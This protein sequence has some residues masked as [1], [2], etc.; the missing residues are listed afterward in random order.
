MKAV[1][2]AYEYIL[3]GKTGFYNYETEFRK[4]DGSVL[5]IEWNATVLRDNSNY[6]SSVATIGQDV[7]SRKRA[8]T[9]LI[10]AKSKAEESDK[11][12]SIFL[13]NMSHEI[14]T[15]MNAIM[16]FSALLGNDGVSEAEKHQFINI[17][18]SSGDRLLNIINDI[19][20]ISKIEAKQLSIT[21]SEFNLSDIFRISLDSFRNSELLKAKSEINLTIRIDERLKHT[22][23]IS[24]RYRIQQVLDNL[25]SNSIKYTEK[26]EIETGFRIVDE[27][28]TDMIEAWVKDTGIGI[29]DELHEIIFERFRQADENKFH[30]GAGLGLSITKGIID[31]LNG[32]IWFASIIKQGTTFYF[33]IPLVISENKPLSEMKTASGVPDL[34]GKT[35]IIA[36]DDYNSFYY[37]RLLLKNLNANVLHAENGSVLMRLV[38]HK[39]P[40]L[41][42]LDINMPVMSGYQ[43]LDELKRL[44][45]KTKIIAQTAYAMSSER[46]K[47]LQ[48]GCDGYISKPIT[49][50]DLYTELFNVFAE[51]IQK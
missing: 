23:I 30:E 41:I 33:K 35:V 27:N 10:R 42:L 51:T 47:C 45:I 38:D 26:G 24:D 25:I 31:L 28:G 12:K 11:L 37:L 16:G 49:K 50:T 18:Q 34:H 5:S 40:D 1:K 7:T 36:E 39:V 6:I 32:K 8:E 14:R 2:D 13:S 29:P 20:D 48:S 17:I 9:E 4:Y 44:G 15:P 3:R 22:K 46:E 43:C 21:L 19:I